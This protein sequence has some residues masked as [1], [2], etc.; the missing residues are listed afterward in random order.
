MWK[1]FFFFSANDRRAILLLSVTLLAGV[2]YLCLHPQGEVQPASPGEADSIK[3][4]LLPSSGDSLY[5]CRQEFALQPFDPNEADSL[6]LMALGLKPHVVRNILRYRDAGGIFRTPK[7]L[8]RIYGMTDEE[9]TRLRPYIHIGL[10]YRP[11]PKRQQTEKKRDY[12]QFTDTVAI[13]RY[14][15]KYPAGTVIDLNQADT[16]QLKRVPGIGSVLSRRIIAYRE[17]LGGFVSLSQL[18]EIYNLPEGIGQWF[19]LSDTLPRKINL[20]ADSIPR[21]PYLTY[22]QIRIITRHR[23]QRGKL[24]SLQQLSTYP[25]FSP[26]DLARLK[27]YVMF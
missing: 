27:P 15:A 9:F 21:H 12:K 14:P 10:K 11:V 6:T 1:D 19:T 24:K 13:A 3:A 2:V 23:Q 25:E 22:R 5:T 18:Q 4:S 8:S 20:N 26:A 16:C 7:A 17:R